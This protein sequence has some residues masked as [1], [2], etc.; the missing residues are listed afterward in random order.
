[1]INI[2]T[3]YELIK[4]HSIIVALEDSLFS[5]EIGKPSKWKVSNRKVDDA[6]NIP[7]YDHEAKDMEI[8]VVNLDIMINEVG[9]QYVDENYAKDDVICDAQDEDDDDYS[10]LI[11]KPDHF[12]KGMNSK[13]KNII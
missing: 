13:D 11:L 8:D 7:N 1:M 10:H 3:N 6:S 9:T 12:N 5:Y 4:E 2:L